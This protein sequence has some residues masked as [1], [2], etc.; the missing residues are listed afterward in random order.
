MK[1][2]NIVTFSFNL[3]LRFLIA[4]YRTKKVSISNDK[5]LWNIS[6]E[7][8]D[9]VWKVLWSIPYKQ[10]QRVSKEYKLLILKMSLFWGYLSV[11]HVR[12]VESIRV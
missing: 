1:K 10:L 4:L 11:Q 2:E 7:K 12:V 5:W 8:F 6:R 9:S 3:L